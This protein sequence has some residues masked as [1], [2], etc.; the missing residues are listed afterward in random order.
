MAS[1]L[2]SNLTALQE[3]FGTALLPGKSH[4]QKCSQTLDMQLACLANGIWVMQRGVTQRTKGSM[5][6]MEFPIP[7]IR[8]FG[9]IATVSKK[10]RVL[11]LRA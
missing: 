8:P 3:G 5:S 10:M 9:L 1:A 2:G 6:G 4:L 11:S 7:L